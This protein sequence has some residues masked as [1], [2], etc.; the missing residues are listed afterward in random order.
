MSFKEIYREELENIELRECLSSG[1]TI[2][3]QKNGLDIYRCTIATA[4][5]RRIAGLQRSFKRDRL[6][7]NPL[8]QWDAHEYR[9]AH[10]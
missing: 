9:D 10:R 2:P 5:D 4:V 7:G 3:E 1:E 8:L 6:F